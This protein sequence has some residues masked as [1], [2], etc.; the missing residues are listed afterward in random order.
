MTAKE[1]KEALAIDCIEIIK[2]ITSLP[3][4]PNKLVKN[5][6]KL[7]ISNLHFKNYNK[8]ITISKSQVVLFDIIHYYLC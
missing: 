2:T 3:K 1:L 4:P 8:K 7:S 6:T 5:S